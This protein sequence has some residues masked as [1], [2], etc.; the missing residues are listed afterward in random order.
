MCSEEGES[1]VEGRGAEKAL[2]V[3]DVDVLLRGLRTVR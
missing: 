2:M 1:G 3:R